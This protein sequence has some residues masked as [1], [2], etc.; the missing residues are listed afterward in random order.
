MN[1]SNKRQRDLKS[2]L[3]AAVA[4]LLVSTIMMVSTTYAW[5]TL[6]TAPEVQGITTT[7]GANGNLEIALSP[8][9][10]DYSKIT[11]GVGDTNGA[12][13]AKNLTWGNLLDLSDPSYG[14]SKIMLL[15][16]QLNIKASET[17]NA[18][19]TLQTNPLKV[20]TYGADGRVDTLKSD[21]VTYG[22][23]RP[24]GNVDGF[25]VNSGTAEDIFGVR[26]VGT[27]STQSETALNFQTAL[28][29]INNNRGAANSQVSVA[30][31]TY[32]GSLAGVAIKYANG[33]ESGYEAYKADMKALINELDGASDK[34]EV[35]LYNALLAISI[36]DLPT[37]IDGEEKIVDMTV[38]LNGT[39]TKIYDAIKWNMENG[40]PFSTT[41]GYFGSYDAVIEY[42]FP[43]LANA[44]EAWN[45][46]NENVTAAKAAVEALGETVSKSEVMT[47]VKYLMDYSTD[48]AVT[49]NGT[50]LDQVKQDPTSIFGGGNS[51]INLQLNTGSGV[52]AY[53][54]ELTGNV[55]APV[56]VPEGTTVGSMNVGGMTVNIVTTTEPAG[57][58]LLKQVRD[59]IALIG[60]TKKEGESASAS[61]IDVTYG[62]ALDFVFRTN[63]ANSSLL[64]Q[65]DAAQ[66]IYGD[67]QNAA[68]MGAG[69][70]LSFDGKFL[71]MDSLVDM[72]S[73]IRVVFTE[74]DGDAIYGIAK[75]SI[76]E[77]PMLLNAKEV[78]VSQ[79][80]NKTVYTDGD[81]ADLQYIELTAVPN[82]T[83]NTLK[84]SV[85]EYA[86]AG[87]IEN[88]SVETVHDETKGVTYQRWTV[89]E[90]KRE[91]TVNNYTY[92]IDETLEPVYYHV[93]DQDVELKGELSLHKYTVDATGKLSFGAVED[94]QS[95]TTLDQNVATG[96]TALVYLDGDY[97]DNA[98][99]LNSEDG[100][101]KT[102]VLNLQFAS[103]ANLVPM[104]N[105]TLHNGFGVSAEI[106]A[107]YAEE[108]TFNGAAMTAANTAYDFSIGAPNGATY[109]VSYS[110][111]GTAKGE[112]TGTA[113]SF[114]IEATNVTGNI[115]IQV[116]DI[117]I[118]EPETTV[119]TPSDPE[120]NE[121]TPSE[122]EGGESTPSD[123]SG[124]SA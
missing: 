63:A 11:T 79:V 75:I 66:R 10:R 61:V 116:T 13:T 47:V 7:V 18:A 43:A 56:N 25:I 20:P 110:V 41:W 90:V 67:S 92:A 23:Q 39:P 94:V 95:L 36:S 106:P 72:M 89:K 93:Y 6:S 69:S 2:K 12:W 107:E 60:V 115:V 16:S 55:S 30:L 44:Y 119:T 123:P 14:L 81:D 8:A 99:I 74:T 53:F 122:P 5:F 35:A 28:S 29:T 97:I 38:D 19:N 124:E 71:D 49:I 86:V 91:G 4:M 58:A 121:S 76:N 77:L 100:V 117:V 70:T 34:I 111:D 96:V 108:I 101:F 82:G 15:P 87:N 120:E 1:N 42:A 73:G 109:K 27:S 98:D 105:S 33:E 40:M 114:K 65:S 83:T 88:V 102:G 118:P 59:T 62:Y 113:G 54:G 9:D 103:S 51:G 78:T 26:A 3:I 24:N 80:D 85:G 37:S 31:S 45:K 32:G 17:G 46:I 22:A 50:P 52:L 21:G 84:W 104:N 48:N 64:L 112:L 57:G 68:T